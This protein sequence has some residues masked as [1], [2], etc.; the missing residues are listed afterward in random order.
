VIDDEPAICRVLDA[1]LRLRGY[2]V[3]VARTAEAGLQ[4]ASA[5]EPDVT[6]VD[7]GLPDLDGVEVCRRLR[8]W[9]AN[10]I[11]VL[12]VEDGEDRKVEALDSGA[13]DYVSKPFSMP[14]LLARIRVAARHR[15]A[16]AQVTE[17]DVLRVGRLT[18]DVAVHE[19]RI[20]GQV[21]QLA[22]KEFAVLAMLVRNVGHLTP[23]R[24]LLTGV[25]GP[26]AS[27]LEL[28]RGLIHQLR[29]KLDRTASSVEIVSEPGIGYRLIALEDA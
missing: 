5:I 12:T 6:I 18:L 13:D 15:R 23:N 9:N 17:P 10:P 24:M 14:E 16:L 8:R 20:D 29:R 28:V 21:V 4:L 25:W 27:R 2:E 7:L 19:A 11:L 26:A 22:P 3:V 1:A